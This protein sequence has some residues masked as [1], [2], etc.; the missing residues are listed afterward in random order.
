MKCDYSAGKCLCFRQFQSGRFD[1]TFEQRDSFS[2]QNRI[3]KKPKLVNQTLAQ[4][5]VGGR[6]TS[7]NQDILPLLF[8][9]LVDVVCKVI[10]N[11]SGVV[12]TFFADCSG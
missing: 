9:Y 11:D 7:E 3:D 1:D 10:A 5:G 12:K 8:F 2:K 4:Q 6:R